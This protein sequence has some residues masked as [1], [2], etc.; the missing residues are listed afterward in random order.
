MSWW[1]YLNY[2]D[3]RSCLVP[4][5]CEGGTYV[6]SRVNEYGGL[7]S[8]TQEAELNITYNYSPFYY[9]T[10]DAEEGIR[11]LAGKMAKI[12][13]PILE[14]AVDRLGADCDPDYW[15]PTPG[16]AGYALSILLNWA[17]L[18]EEAIFHVS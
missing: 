7:E 15:L 12:C 16:N 14:R 10:I 13:I 4:S 11:W 5:H 3:G 1:V 17:K 2:S 18:H 6:L 8:G 9:E